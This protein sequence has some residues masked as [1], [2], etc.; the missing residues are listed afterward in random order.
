M[1]IISMARIKIKAITFAETLL[2]PIRIEDAQGSPIV[3][4]IK[5]PTIRK[6]PSVA[7]FSTFTWKG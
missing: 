5:A 2:V 3:I 1:A 4:A 6:Q 7:S